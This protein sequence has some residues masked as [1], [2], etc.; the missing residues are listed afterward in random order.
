MK[1]LLS[2]A[3]ALLF[4]FTSGCVFSQDSVDSLLEAPK[5]SEEQTEIYNALTT[6]QGKNVVLKYPQNGDY[7]S[8]FLV[9]DFG[10]TAAEQALALYQTQAQDA[11]IHLFF[12]ETDKDG[13]WRGVADI[14]MEGNEVDSV[15]LANFDGSGSAV[16]VGAQNTAS[17]ARVLSIY[18][19]VN[20]SISMVYST[21]YTSFY[22]T[23]LD[24]DSLDELLLFAP[25]SSQDLLQLS[26]VQPVD[27]TLEVTDTITVEN[28]GISILNL[29]SGYTG[30]GVPAVYLDYL[31]S[32]GGYS[33]N[34]Y[35]YKDGTLTEGISVDL[36]SQVIRVS[37]QE[38]WD[39]FGDSVCL[40]PRQNTMSGYDDTTSSP[41]WTVWQSFDSSTRSLSVRLITYLNLSMGYA[42]AF[43]E[44][45]T[46]RLSF[47]TSDTTEDMICYEY[48]TGGEVFRIRTVKKSEEDTLPEG[49]TILG[50]SGQYL[51]A[52]K[53]TN[54]CSDDLAQTAESLQ[55]RLYFYNS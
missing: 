26:V 22:V 34:L 16:I 19:Y 51:Y 36:R 1:R 9:E 8:A 38:S 20:G 32:A 37:Q 3:A 25:D 35:Y 5:L 18:R 40:I 43:S 45:E 49:Y 42:L 10:G 14:S 13:D 46:A 54:S 27:D 47:T 15:A 52:A 29:Q 44:E 48:D 28:T 50:S 7:R 39:A 55:S 24:G 41:C 33:S 4:L 2:I 31:Q 23:D 6:A 21:S 30:D 12:L 11:Y 53:I 17:D